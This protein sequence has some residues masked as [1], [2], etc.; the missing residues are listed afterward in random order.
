MLNSYRLSLIQII[1]TNT[2]NVSSPSALTLLKHT[3]EK[4]K[5]FSSLE[6]QGASG[7]AVRP[8]GRADRGAQAKAMAA[9]SVVGAITGAKK[10]WGRGA[11][12]ASKAYAKHV[13]GEG[14]SGS[15]DS[16]STDSSSDSSDDDSSEEEE[17]ESEDDE[18]DEYADEETLS[19]GGSGGGPRRSELRRFQRLQ[20]RERA[21]GGART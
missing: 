4:N 5:R 3:H 1:T 16:S 8:D 18:D 7:S 15:S 2:T 17:S 11:R 12:A 19:S 14:S 13:K 6:S 20:A 21:K 9:R 10:L